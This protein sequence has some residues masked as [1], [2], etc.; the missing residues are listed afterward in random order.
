[1]LLYMNPKFII[2]LC[3]TLISKNIHYENILEN[4]P[5]VIY[6]AFLHTHI[7]I[8]SQDIR[9]FSF[10]WIRLDSKRKGLSYIN[11]REGG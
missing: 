8:R 11:G 4:F 9:R 6:H 10:R 3:K 2:Y 1:M 5:L 7:L